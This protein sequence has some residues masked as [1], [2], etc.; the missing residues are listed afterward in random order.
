M[1]DTLK[2][3]SWNWQSILGLCAAGL[4]AGCATA[5]RFTAHDPAPDFRPPAIVLPYDPATKTGVDWETVRSAQWYSYSPE[6]MMGRAAEY[7]QEGIRRMTGRELAV[8]GTNDFSH[9]IVLL[10]WK[11]APDDIRNDAKVSAA[12]AA[13]PKDH[14]AANEAFYIRSEPNRVLVVANTVDGLLGAVVELMES[15]DYE[16]LGM[17]PDWIHAPD[18]RNRPLA[19]SIDRAGQPGF[20]IRSLCAM[21]GQSYGVGTIVEGL[22]D[23]ADEPVW[24]SYRRWHIGARM[25][26]RSMSNF[27][28]HA[29]HAY[30]LAV[31]KQIRD[32]N[33][34][35]GFLAPKIQVGAVADRPAPETA[36][37][38][39][40]WVNADTNASANDLAF[41]SDGKDWQPGARCSL[42]LSVPFVRD[43]I[44]D[45]MIKQASDR[46]AKG[47]GDPP[48]NTI[49]FAMDPEDGGGY[50][51]LKTL[52][53]HPDW[54]PDYLSSEGI[55][56]GQPY[57]LNG[58]NGLNQPREL[59][60]P[61]AASDMVYGLA[62]YL[63]REF[64]KW[65]DSLP[66]A[67]RVLPDGRSKKEMIRCS[68]YCY[69]FHD[70]PP[71]FNLDPRIRVQIAGFPKNRGRGKWEKFASQE[72]MA[73]AFQKMLPREP[74]GDYRIAS[75]AYFRDQNLEGLPA[76][77]DASASALA[78]DYRNLYESGYRAVSIETDF[79]FGKFGLAYYLTAKML[80]NPK[81][82]AEELNAIRD[83]WLQRAFGAAWKEMKTY[84]DFM[85]IGNYPING[86]G[87]W[88]KAISMID[89][90]GKKL[91]GAKEP[92]ARRR[93][94]DLKQFWY[95][96]YLI[97]SDK[98]TPDSPE[99]REFIWKGQ[100]SYMVAMHAPVYKLGYLGERKDGTLIE[101]TLGPELSSGPAHYTHEE[102]QAWWTKVLEF[103]PLVPVQ[104]FRAGKLA[105]GTSAAAVDLNDLVA[106]REFASD[107]PDVPFYGN[108]GSASPRDVSFM[109]VA[110][111]KGEE[112]GFKLFWPCRPIWCPEGGQYAAMK[113][114]YGA[115]VWNPEKK[116]WE[117]WI[118]RTMTTQL[119]V[120]MPAPDGKNWKSWQVAEIR[121]KAPRPGV[122]RFGF[123]I[124][125]D[126]GGL[127][128]LGY[129]P[130][131]EK[132]ERT[133]GFTFTGSISGLTQN[134]S[135]FY[136]PKGTRSLDFEIWDPNAGKTLVL[137][138]GL[139]SAKPTVSRTLDVSKR[140]SHVIPLEPGEDGTVAELQS[141]G[142]DFP[143]MYSIPAIWAKSP[144]AL[145]VPRAIAR[146]DGLTLPSRA[147]R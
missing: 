140:G 6:V 145:M 105:D 88:A 99:T 129:D 18:Y 53:K 69:N 64:D 43:I 41:T 120:E 32:M 55:K 130:R 54:Y 102:T 117:L 28:G 124:A 23:P 56:F 137:Y 71:N 1:S 65:V 82:T 63:L 50:D 25:A 110:T 75:V 11:Y 27:P 107:K 17:G 74:S 21:C 91:D 132:S 96:Y 126:A 68:F 81:M 136:I 48:D 9:G 45:D 40:L 31:L 4:M 142:F 38:G 114:P 10:L 79:N 127:C 118:D 134:P 139:P 85:L 87:S 5:E 135:Y 89:A 13:N 61:E 7:V 78:K 94:D 133:L 57:V 83:R 19:F 84:Y 59:W 108:F 58:H 16:I 66:E 8:V 147:Q 12:L 97:A 101:K 138:K 26:G 73:R 141:N 51:R 104:D 95:Y 93:I 144:G 112:I 20:Y 46:F 33:K 39:W 76:H 29:L 123:D 37:A 62:N 86:P 109:E 2:R 70:V 131:T 92:D 34:A 121:L 14:Y 72:D 36:N 143:Y 122:Y 128:S 116:E 3:A 106:V 111:E 113:V 98:Y 90:A 52:L 49:I 42:D 47:L 103:W 115:E 119:S 77:W 60:D 22:T 30:H 125:G 146:A 67:E 44:R 15:A 35:E 80:W 24:E 100:M